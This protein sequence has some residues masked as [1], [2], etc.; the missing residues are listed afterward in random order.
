M[1]WSK[2]IGSEGRAR[3]KTRS[4]TDKWGEARQANEVDYFIDYDPKFF[5]LSKVEDDSDIPF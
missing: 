1:D 2:V 3:F 4:Y 5:D